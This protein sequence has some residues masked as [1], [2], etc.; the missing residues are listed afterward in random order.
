[1]TAEKNRG[2]DNLV[3]LCI[4][5]SYEIDEKPDM[6][7][8]EM[9]RRWKAAQIAEYDKILRSWS[10]S[11]DEAT[12]ALIASEAFETLRAPSTLELVRR[13]EA[14]RLL[15]ER[16]RSDARRWARRWQQLR[17]R[18]HNSSSMW[19]EDGNTIYLEPSES[20]VRPIREGIQ[21]ALE[22]AINDLG[23]AADAARVELAA[24]RVTSAQISPWCDDLNG[25]IIALMDTAGS[26]AGGSNPTLDTAFD[27]TLENLQRSVNELVRA[28]RGEDVERPASP[29]IVEPP[30]VTDP[31]A[32]HRTLLDEARPFS[33]VTHRLYDP[34]LRERIAEATL[35]AS[36][37]PPTVH[38]LAISLDVTAALAAA[39]ARNATKEEKLEL[40]NRDRQ[41]LPICAAT[42]LLQQA[43]RGDSEGNFLAVAASE[44]LR[45]LWWD[46]DWSSETSWVGNDVNGQSMMWA[47][48]NAMSDSE[49]RMRLGQVLEN[50]PQLLT[51]LVVSCAGWVE[52][53]DSS[54]WQLKQF[55]RRYSEIPPWLPIEEIRALSVRLLGNHQ[56]PDDLTTLAAILRH[57]ADE[58]K[59]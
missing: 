11:D 17:E 2:P 22:A 51:Q 39:V 34:D 35:T 44:S 57:S 12:E 28:S 45:R 46:T 30:S 21:A 5:H 27:Q 19:D 1:M 26:W 23:P 56:S 59:Y 24:I 15:A 47:F 55:E 54:T 52:E 9:L 25:A 7:P 42:A 43:A 20:E 6:F 13:V 32:Q 50:S 53:L 14:L 36:E 40:M 41:R 31:L 49:L 16:T 37:I 58:S 29:S 10:I 48:A 18:T 4:E 33:R 3:I 8:A 38:F